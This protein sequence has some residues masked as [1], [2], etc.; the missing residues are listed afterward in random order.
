M[1]LKDRSLFITLGKE[2]RGEGMG[3]REGVCVCDGE[4]GG[5][6]VK[7]GRS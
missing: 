2:R 6:W 7:N 5:F 1:V 4:G 3:D